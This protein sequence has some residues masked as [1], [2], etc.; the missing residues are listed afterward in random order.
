LDDRERIERFLDTSIEK[1]SGYPGSEQIT[2][3]KGNTDWRIRSS[4]HAAA[5][6]KTID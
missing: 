1:N 4:D 2:Q 3:E 6:G 5:K